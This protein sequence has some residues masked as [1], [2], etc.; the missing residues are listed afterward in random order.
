MYHFPPPMLPTP[1]AGTTGAGAGAAGAASTG[2]AGAGAASTGTA[3][4]GAASTGTAG[5]GTASTGTAGAGAASTGTAG[6][7]GG[8]VLAP[9]PAATRRPVEAGVEGPTVGFSA[10]TEEAKND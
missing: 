3:G 10:T 9:A 5:V 6:A 8:P 4:V 1:C 2:T 7:V